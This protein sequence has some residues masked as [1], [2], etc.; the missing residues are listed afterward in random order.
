MPD[1]AMCMNGLCPSRE[2]CYRFTAQP[3]PYRQTYSTFAPEDG[4]DKCS[5]YWETDVKPGA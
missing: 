1:I 3:N 2:T 5:Y 4:K